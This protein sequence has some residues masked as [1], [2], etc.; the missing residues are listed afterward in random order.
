MNPHPIR[1]QVRWRCH[2]GM[3]ELDLILLPFL[4]QKYDQLSILEQKA[5]IRLLEFSDPELYTWL[6]TEERPDDKEISAIVEF[7]H[8]KV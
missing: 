7:I 1:S 2:R 5:F 6:L 4:D 8:A 3:L